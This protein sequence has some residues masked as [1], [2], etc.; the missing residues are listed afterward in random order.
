MK[1]C[2]CLLLSVLLIAGCKDDWSTERGSV[3]QIEAMD[4]LRQ[5]DPARSVTVLKQHLE[6]KPR[7]DMAWTLLGHAHEDLAQEDEAEAAYKK[8]LEIDPRR[9]QAL[10]GLGILSRKRG[11]NDEAMKYYEQAIAI[12]PEW[13]NAY[14]SMTVICLMEGQDAKALEYAKKG[15]DLDSSEPAAIANLAVAYHYNG[16]IELRD[17]MTE[18]A[19]NRGYKNVD[20]LQKIYSGELSVRK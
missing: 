16:N 10:T 6:K 8:A 5:S 15:Y 7:D 20:T 1:Y 17:K 14:S 3:E 18:E 13:G 12:N 19:K 9:F 4:S 11:K 2:F